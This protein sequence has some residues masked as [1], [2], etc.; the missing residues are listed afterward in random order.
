MNVSIYKP[1][2]IAFEVTDRCRFHCAY[3]RMKAQNRHAP[4]MDTLTCKKILVAI[5][6]YHKCLV[7]FTGGEPLERPDLFGLL[8]YAR[9][10][11][12]SVALATC[13][14]L[15]NDRVVKRL[16]DLDIVSLSLSLDGASSKTHD[17]HHGSAGAFDMIVRTAKLA[18]KAGLPFQINTTVNRDN[19]DEIKDIASLAQ[20][21]GAFC[22]NPFILI[23]SEPDS[24]TK[25]PFLNLVEYEMLLNE[26]FLIKRKYHLAVRVS[27]GPQY[28]RM[29]EP[30][31][32]EKRLG[33]H[34]MGGRSFAYITHSGD[35]QACGFPDLIAGNLTENNFDFKAIWEHSQ[36]YHS[37]D[38]QKNLPESCQHCD[39]LQSCGGCRARAYA[40][41]GQTLA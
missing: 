39:Y 15:V 25:V 38:Q 1:R 30:S 21:L 3:C 11:G 12:L 10:L 24:D 27:C 28:G 23:P 40:V 33:I 37:S 17:Q 4:E 41:G 31:N 29:S 9:G 34:K 7:V 22:F 16:K 32:A 18:K 36:G 8:K 6:N 20:S 13:G 35:I 14:Y 26:L 2:L 5:A 19:L